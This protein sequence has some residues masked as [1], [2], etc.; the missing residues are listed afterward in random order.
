MKCE[1]RRRKN[2]FL[3]SSVH[4]SA[5]RR[6]QLYLSR[7]LSLQPVSLSLSFSL[8]SHD[9]FVSFSK[10]TSK[11]WITFFRV[12]S[13][14]V[15]Q[16]CRFDLCFEMIRW[17]PRYQDAE[18]KSHRSSLAL[19]SILTFEWTIKF[20]LNYG[21]G[22]EPWIFRIFFH[23]FENL[24]DVH[25]NRNKFQFVSMGLNEFKSSRWRRQKNP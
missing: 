6:K 3:V 8:Y 24:I 2:R 9:N 10:D 1:W 20:N 22:R 12:V 14:F 21:F 16:Q 17:F 18:V 19:F 23:P 4:G 25:S 15:R 7:S 13:P 11:L 5:R